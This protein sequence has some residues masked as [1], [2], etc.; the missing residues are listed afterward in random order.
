QKACELEDCIWEHMEN[1]SHLRP[2]RLSQL[3]LFHVGT[4][5]RQSDPLALTQLII[6]YHVVSAYKRM[7]QEEYLFRPL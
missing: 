6:L 2:D 1:V 7:T 5:L 3:G 4:M